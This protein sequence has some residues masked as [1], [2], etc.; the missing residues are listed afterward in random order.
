MIDASSISQAVKAYGESA[1]L[2][3]VEELGSAEET[4]AL[5]ELEGS[6][7]L[8]RIIKY[9]TSDEKTFTRRG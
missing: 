7:R 3:L 4:G 2:D 6:L 5:L 9:Q 1:V 8:Q